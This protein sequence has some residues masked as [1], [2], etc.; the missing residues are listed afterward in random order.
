MKVTERLTRQ[1]NSIR[2]QATVEDPVMLRPFV[3]DPRTMNLNPDPNAKLEEDLPCS[4]R[5]EPHIVTHERG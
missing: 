1:G 5:D 2:Y 3:M 4:E